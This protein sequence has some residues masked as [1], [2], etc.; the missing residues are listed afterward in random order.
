[1]RLRIS[2]SYQPLSTLTTTQIPL[3]LKPHVNMADASPNLLVSAKPSESGLTVSL[4]PLV[5]LTVSDQVTRQ[6]TRKLQGPVAGALLG[7][8]K[9]REITAEHAFPVAL[10]KGPHGRWQ[11]DFEW[12]TQRIQQCEF[13]S[14]P[15]DSEA[16]H[17]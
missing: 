8:Q 13:R 6:S 11:F 3:P 4:H 9:G 12:M 7:Q 1:M 17:S 15:Y 10:E 14:Q 5:L 16:D 2:L